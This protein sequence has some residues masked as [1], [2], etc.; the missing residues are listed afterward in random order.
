MLP[1]KHLWWHQG[2]RHRGLLRHAMTLLSLCDGVLQELFPR[3]YAQTADWLWRERTANQDTLGRCKA[4]LLAALDTDPVLASL[5][6]SCQVCRPGTFNLFWPKHGANENKLKT[7]QDQ[8][9]WIC[10]QISE[11][12]T[13]KWP[14]KQLGGSFEAS[15]RSLLT[16]TSV[17]VVSAMQLIA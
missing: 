9:A 11:E 15:L 2:K 1:F 17:L 10:G 5:A 7:S 4:D 12:P 13:Y 6:V 16:I 14:G 8:L 3:S